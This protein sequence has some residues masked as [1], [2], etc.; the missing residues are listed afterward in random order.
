M[1]K[2]RSQFEAFIA[3]RLDTTGQ[4]YAY[5]LDR[6]NFVQPSKK[7]YYKPDFHLI[8]LGFFI[9][10]KGLF[11][12]SDRKKHLWIKEQHPELDIR[13]V[14]QNAQLPI[15]T[16]SKTTCAMWCDKHGFKW[17]HKVVPREWITDETGNNIYKS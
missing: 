2:F 10:V 1:P 14:F 4:R 9:E 5:E 8:D 12:A 7:R 16:G 6:I 3:A 17:S 13:F 15:R 11:R